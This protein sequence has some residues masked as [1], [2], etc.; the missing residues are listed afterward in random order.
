M[1][2]LNICCW[3]SA[4]LFFFY[5]PYSS[6]LQKSNDPFVGYLFFLPAESSLVLHGIF[7]LLDLVD[8][9]DTEGGTFFSFVF[10]LSSY[11]WEYRLNWE[12]S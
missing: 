11:F 10:L 4:T 1:S 9:L 12:S 5:T 8:C 3:D 6:D 2:T 7:R